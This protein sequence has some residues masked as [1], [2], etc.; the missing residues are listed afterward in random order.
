MH[1]SI[2]FEQI[3]IGKKLPNYPKPGCRLVWSLVFWPQGELLFCYQT[4]S[5]ARDLLLFALRSPQ[6]LIQSSLN[7]LKEFTG[8]QCPSCQL[9]LLYTFGQRGRQDRFNQHKFFSSGGQNQIF[10]TYEPMHITS[11]LWSWLDFFQ[12]TKKGTKRQVL[13]PHRPIS[14]KIWSPSA[15]WYK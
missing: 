8:L 14:V 12:M 4:V 2:G 15:R 9:I 11:S 10:D 6:H 13:V 3:N 1:L 5:I 7:S